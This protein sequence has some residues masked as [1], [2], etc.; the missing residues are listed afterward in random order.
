MCG[1]AGFVLNDREAIPDRMIVARMCDRIAHRG[2]DAEGYYVDR[3][4][5]LGHR[6][7]SII[8]L[9]TGSQPLGNEDGSVQVVFN[10]E[11]YNYLEIR[12][13]L[14]EKGHRFSTHSDTEVLV[15]LYEE[16]GERMP[17]F[18]N[19]MFAFAIWDSRK[20]ELF[21]ARDRLG[22]KPLYY[23]GD[24]PGFRFCFASELKA[25]ATLPRFEAAINERSVADFLCLS[26]V[27]DPETIYKNVFKLRPGCSLLVSSSGQRI[28]RY[29]SPV[30]EEHK[31]FCYQEKVEELRSL[32][33]DSVTCRMMSD[34]PLGAFLSGGV[35][36]SSVVAAMA[37]QA[38]GFIKTFSIGFDSPEFDE[39]EYAH[40]IVERYRTEHHEEVVTPSVYDI[41]AKLVDHFDEPFADSSAVPTLYLSRMTRRHVTVALSGD[42]ADE[43]FGGYRR[44][45]WEICEHRIRSLFPDWF[46]HT[47]VSFGAT[48]Y[49]TFTYMPRIFRAKAT[50]NFIAKDLGDAYFTHMSAFRDQPVDQVLSGEMRKGLSGYSPRED[51]LH[52]FRQFSHLSPLRQ[53]QAVDL[54]TYL[55]GDILVKIDRA[56]MAFSLEARCPWLDYRLAEFAGTLPTDFLLRGD[57]GKRILKDAMASSLPSQLIT[58]RK[59]GFAVPLA[60]WLRSSLRPLFES[61]VLS[62]DMERYVALP[63]IRQMWQEHQSGRFNHDRKLWHLL[64]LAAWDAWHYRNAPPNVFAEAVADGRAV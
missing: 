21:V 27:P 14:I 44:Y 42:G 19:G 37:G 17:E 22:K 3:G 24:I 55:P 49:P 36:S 4:V 20:Q 6:R 11:I 38:P 16:T 57:N 35:D 1:I 62:A 50:L 34:V 33:Q 46:R 12:R 23:S 41:L 29:W 56:A 47:A 8:D 48:H 5:A 30:F 26:Y 61:L 52:R 59:M 2:P 45:Y 64:M 10:G 63:K 32:A 60:K 13:D 28:R 40:Q 7:L 58:R 39:L 51:F 54:E 31:G 53:M 15:H 25:L 9:S 43:V 18:L